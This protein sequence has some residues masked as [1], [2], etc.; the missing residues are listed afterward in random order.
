MGKKIIFLI[1]KHNKNSVKSLCA[2]LEKAGVL[3]EIEFTKDVRKIK[4]SNALVLFSLSTPYVIQKRG[5]LEETLKKLNGAVKIA[6]GPHPSGDPRG[7][8]EMGFDY[9]FI[10]E[11]EKS[12]PEIVKRFLDGKPLEGIKGLYKKGIKVSRGEK[13]RLD[14]YPPVSIHYRRLG[15]IEIARGCPHGCKFCQTS[16]LFGRDVRERSVENTIFWV[17]RI[18]SEG[19]RDIRFIAPDAFSYGGSPETIEKLLVK[20][21]DVVGSR[22]KIYFGTFPSEVRP[23]S[24][25]KEIV[26]LVK[27]LCDN[28]RIGIGA[29]S[30]SDRILRATSRGHTPDDV[31]EAVEIIRK[32]GLDVYVDFIFG[33]PGET[34]EDEKET[35]KL[36]KELAKLGAYIHGHT[37]MPLSGTPYY[38]KK[39]GTLSPKIRK[40]MGELASKGIA[41]GKWE[42]QEKVYR[43]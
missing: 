2:S 38:R 10:G 22:G 24:V 40:L 19:I 32:E 8:L 3:P 43:S 7:T 5:W 39:P 9:V 28:K 12:F 1:N 35:I 16:Y 31:I 27:R 42:H 14:S 34:E 33:L 29:Q 21:R 18:F 17:K 4:D 36:I 41:F 6:G 25:K 15:A 26:E 23:E 20:A 37:F 13:I 30:G 11:G